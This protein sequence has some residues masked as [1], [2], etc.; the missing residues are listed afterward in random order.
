MQNVYWM[1]GWMDTPQTVTTTRA[2][3]V[4]TKHKLRTQNFIKGRKK[5][6]LLEIFSL[7]AKMLHLCHCHCTVQLMAS[8]PTHEA[9][10]VRQ[11]RAAVVENEVGSLVESQN[12]RLGL[13]SFQEPG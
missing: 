13:R 2:H 4:L 5:T 3:A 8:L 11:P 12:L 10:K 6:A 9:T 1:D 7:F